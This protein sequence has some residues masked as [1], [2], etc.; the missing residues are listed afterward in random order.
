MIDQIERH[1][2]AK[3]VISPEGLIDYM[4]TYNNLLCDEE[5]SKRAEIVRKILDVGIQKRT[6]R[7]Y[8]GL[9][10]T[11]T[12]EGHRVDF[13]MRVTGSPFICRVALEIQANSREFLFRRQER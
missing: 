6:I 8:S 10:I 1:L 13:T 9:K 2:A 3:D 12:D 4:R 5:I 7:S 11:Q